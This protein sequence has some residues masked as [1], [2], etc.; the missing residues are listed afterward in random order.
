MA[1]LLI[2]DDHPMVRLGIETLLSSLPGLDA[3]TSVS[4]A[5]EARA[6]LDAAPHDVA[7]VDLTLHATDGG[8]FIDWL[9]TFHPRTRVVVHTVHPEDGLAVRL[10][11]RGVSAYVHK[12]RD[13]DVL[14]AAVQKAIGGGRYLTDE[15]AERL[16]SPSSASSGA[17]HESLSAREMQVF[18]MVV[19]GRAPTHI[20]AQ[21][22]LSR[23]TVSTHLRAIRE[24]LGANSLH[25][26]VN[27]AHRVG[28]R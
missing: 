12:G 28:L 7:V 20:A 3:V 4:S 2:L 11:R 6:A 18:L 1:R 13:P 26:L 5:A 15:L 14:L 9:L 21:L 8:E 24:K 16:L 17:P 25:D 22:H 10:L 19:E 27:Y 23:S